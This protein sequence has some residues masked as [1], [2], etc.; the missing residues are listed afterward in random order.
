MIIISFDPKVV[1]KF[2]IKKSDFTIILNNVPVSEATT[3]IALV[4]QIEDEALK[5]TIREGI[6]R[7][8]RKVA[9]RTGQLQ[10]SLIA[11]LKSSRRRGS[12][13]RII[14][15]THLDYAEAVDNMTTNQVRHYNEDGYAYYYGH[16]GKII[17]NDPEAEGKAITKLITY[18]G[19]RYVLHA[20]SLIR[21]Y[22]RPF[23]VDPAL[24][25][26]ALGV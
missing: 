8:R 14:L 26:S 1:F 19:K 12:I 5:A 9:K 23:G 6:A 15:G 7:I 25:K 11:N 21:I 10:E 22:A 18:V 2:G 13:T 3:A 17:L 20:N 16:Y 24:L 4:Q